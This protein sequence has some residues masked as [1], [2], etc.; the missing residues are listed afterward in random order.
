MKMMY[1][2]S[3]LAVYVRNNGA[4]LTLPGF[5]SALGIVLYVYDPGHGL[6]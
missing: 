4:D 2:K 3:Q 6:G 5:S 1:W